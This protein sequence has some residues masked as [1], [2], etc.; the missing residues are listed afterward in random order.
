MKGANCH[1]IP[2]RVRNE[3]NLTFETFLALAS[4]ANN[5]LG[6]WIIVQIFSKDVF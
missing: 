3:T 2:K 4:G 5:G 1:I 6:K